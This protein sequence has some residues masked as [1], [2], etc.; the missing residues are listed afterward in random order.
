MNLYDW[1]ADTATTSHITHQREA[2]SS[3]TPLGKSSVTGV[4]GK[5]AAV[6][7]KGTVELVST[8]SG[9]KFNLLLQNVLHVPGTRN[10]LISLG[11]WDAAGGRYVGGKG[12]IT[13]IT[14]N[15]QQVAQGTKIDNNLYK[16][17]LTLRNSHSL[18]S[19]SPTMPLTFIGCE[20]VLNWETWHRR[21]GHVAYSGLR[22]LL[23]KKLVD[24]LHVDEHSPTPD[25]IACTEAKQY[26]EPF[27]KTS[28]RITKSGELTHIDLWGKYAVRSI[29]NNQYYL[30]MVDDAKR[31]I[32]VEFL[33][34][35]SE[36]T[37]GVINYLAHLIAQGQTPKAIQIDGGRE[38]VNANLERWCKEH[39]IKIHLT[40]PYSPSQNGV[41]E[42]MN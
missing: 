18:L 2:F 1:L 20:P 28:N 4:G 8:F 31:Y 23:D 14:Q 29:N 17:R 19:E 41:A 39:G 6:I 42:R 26:V 12:K 36:A 7:G 38:F 24:G 40:A 35:K 25:C 16:M 32:T 22:K 27:P 15:G 21:F 3:Y 10:N 30:L 9:Q 33:K 34:E 11:R 13:L 5:E 37:Q